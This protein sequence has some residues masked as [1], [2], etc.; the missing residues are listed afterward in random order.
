VAS[1]GGAV[2]PEHAEESAPRHQEVAQ[3][4]GGARDPFSH[5]RR[6]TS[7]HNP[8]VL[9]AV[10][11]DSCLLHIVPDVVT[12]LHCLELIDVVTNGLRLVSLLHNYFTAINYI[13]DPLSFHDEN[14]LILKR[15]PSP[16]GSGER[17]SYP[18][19]ALDWTTLQHAYYNLD[20]GYNRTE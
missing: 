7:E 11:D 17:S 14:L 1:T 15:R 12:P 10:V 9:K 4:Y 20:R 16:H 5:A 19:L 3:L 18:V 2:Q 8:D 6:P 13:I